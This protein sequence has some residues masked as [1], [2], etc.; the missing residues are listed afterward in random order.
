MRDSWAATQAKIG[1][2]VN[3]R[4][5]TRSGRREETRFRSSGS[6]RVL[7]FRNPTVDSD[8]PIPARSRPSAGRG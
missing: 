5:L 2:E 7:R 6:E 8:A 3:I 4:S 1:P